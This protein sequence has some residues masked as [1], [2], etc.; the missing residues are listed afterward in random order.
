MAAALVELQT[1]D[2]C[3]QHA[4]ASGAPM[5]T[6]GDTARRA[7]EAAGLDGEKA[8]NFASKAAARAV[9]AEAVFRGA[10]PEQVGL[11]TL[12]A[13]QAAGL[14]GDD[15][16]QAAAQQSA[17]AFLDGGAEGRSA[18]EARAAA[19]QAAVACGLPPAQASLHV[20]HAVAEAAGGAALASGMSHEQV[21]RVIQAALQEAE[22]MATD[23]A[24]SLASVHAI[25]LAVRQAVAG[26]N[27]SEEELNDIAEG[28]AVQAIAHGKTVLQ[29]AL[30][31]QAALRAMGTADVAASQTAALQVAKA[32]SADAFAQGR[33][34][35]QVAA[36]VN[37]AAV[38]C[39]VS[40]TEAQM[41]GSCIVAAELQL[42]FQTEGV[43]ADEAFLRAAEQTIA[44][45]DRRGG[46]PSQSPRSVAQQGHLAA[47][48][49]GL[50][51]VDAL[52]TLK[53]LEAFIG[54]AL[55]G[56]GSG[57]AVV[58]VG[59]RVGSAAKTVA[60]AMGLAGD[61]AQVSAS[62]AAGRVM[63]VGAVSNESTPERVGRETHAAVLAA[64]A[65]AEAASEEAAVH[66]VQAYVEQVL[67]PR[68]VPPVR[69]QV[70]T[71][72]YLPP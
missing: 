29:A 53:T 46:T 22:G 58:G 39:G 72:G 51:D 8:A 52:V 7:A 19:R 57:S 24:A 45:V 61:A 59:G 70:S 14:S 10:T 13:V 60:V 32:V 41:L 33:T 23:E 30:E 64:G 17:A 26:G 68:A 44:A 15:A 54:Q 18:G 65:G 21:V 2:A 55:A 28:V 71:P 43:S 16:A 35:E 42:R 9:A 56:L 6:V 3:I 12:E 47:E 50:E 4:L 5:A 1:V 49:L 20:R 67:P 40:A 34:V 36:A 62:E 11:G 69:G 48:A 37:E 63:A 31:T 66:V 38:A 27:V 25:E